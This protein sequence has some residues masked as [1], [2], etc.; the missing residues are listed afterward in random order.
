MSQISTLGG[1]KRRIWNAISWSLCSSVS[2]NK[3]TFIAE[4]KKFDETLELQ[5]V[6][7]ESPK[8]WFIAALTKAAHGLPRLS[9]FSDELAKKK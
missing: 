3:I 9:K 4:A 8:P 1:A 6:S 2:K 7:E 5:V